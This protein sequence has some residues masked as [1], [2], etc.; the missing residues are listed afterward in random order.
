MRI[1]VY[2]VSYRLGKYY[3]TEPARQGKAEQ[4]KALATS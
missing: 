3:T 1:N 4:S 2:C